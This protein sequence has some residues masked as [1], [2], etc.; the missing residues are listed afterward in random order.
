MLKLKTHKIVFAFASAGLV[1]FAVASNAAINELQFFLGNTKSLSANFNQSVRQ[2]SGKVEN[3]R[4]QFFLLRPGKFKWTYAQP[5]NQEII[6]NGQ[7]VWLY[8]LDLAQVTIKPASK[9]LDASPAAILTGNNNLSQ[10]FNLQTLPSKN[11]ISWVALTPKNKDASF[12]QIRIGLLKGQL[13]RMELDDQFNQTTSIQFS[14]MQQNQPMSAQ[15][16]N[17]T[18]PQGVDVIRE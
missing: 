16:F 9:A 3:S 7:Q 17:F 11:G 12:A 18:P 6:S 14:K 1:Q 13:D 4:G 2:K 5:Y 15:A 10:S 8:D